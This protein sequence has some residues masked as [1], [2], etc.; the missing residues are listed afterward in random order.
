MS[1]IIDVM[2]MYV[3][4][5]VKNISATTEAE[6]ALSSYNSFPNQFPYKPIWALAEN[7]RFEPAFVEVNIHDLIIRFFIG[8]LCG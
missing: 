3:I 4:S 8:N 5:F 7:Y 6:T 2:N 1:I